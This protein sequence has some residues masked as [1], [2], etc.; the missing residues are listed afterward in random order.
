[1]EY[2]QYVGVLYTEVFL[3][4][5][6]AGPAILLEDLNRFLASVR[7]AEPVLEGFPDFVFAD[8]RRLAFFMATGSGK[9]LVMHVNLWQV[10][11][12]L[13]AGRHPEALVARTDG[14]AE[15]D[16]IL[17]VTPNEGLTR[18]HLEEFK[19]S[20]IE[21]APLIERRGTTLFGRSSVSSRYTSLRNTPLE[22]V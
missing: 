14:R 4:R 6:T 5:L 12:Y 15:F 19:L 18:Q 7:H 22:K 13:E 11:H 10:L 9:T 20:G 8:L 2:F 1:M 17:L 3:D 16:S 21:A